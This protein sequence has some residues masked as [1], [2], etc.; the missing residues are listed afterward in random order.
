LKADRI[1]V[2]LNVTGDADIIAFSQL[3]LSSD[4]K[5]CLGFQGPYESS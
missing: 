1:D 4:K 2:N 3:N 5:T